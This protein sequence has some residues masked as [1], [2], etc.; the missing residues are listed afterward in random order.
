VEGKADQRAGR[1]T[2]DLE[3]WA[4]HVRELEQEKVA[5]IA[6]DRCA[7]VRSAGG[8]GSH[9]VVQ[10]HR[11]HRRSEIERLGRSVDGRQANAGHIV[12]ERH[13]ERHQLV[14]T[15]RIGGP[16]A[17]DLRDRLS[18]P[19]VCL[20]Q[21]IDRRRELARIGDRVGERIVAEHQERHVLRGR[22]AVEQ[23]KNE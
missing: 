18:A 19:S 12:G 4:P 7:V 9:V 17:Q 6:I 11:S 23:E 22:R 16:H 8:E 15:H 2:E 5:R 20:E 21:R 1:R 10:E 13:E 14:S 3:R